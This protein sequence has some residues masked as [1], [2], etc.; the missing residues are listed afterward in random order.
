M[1]IQHYEARRLEPGDLERKGL[2]RRD[3]VKRDLV[4][5]D[6][7]TR[8]PGAKRRG[9][10]PASALYHSELAMQA[11]KKMRQTNQKRKT[12]HLVCQHL[13]M[14]LENDTS[15]PPKPTAGRHKHQY[16]LGL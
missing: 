4:T 14:M 11:A 9:A 7:A 12:G 10:P 8:T 2:A 13:Q 3:L 5:R 6:P 1:K 15:L 16:R